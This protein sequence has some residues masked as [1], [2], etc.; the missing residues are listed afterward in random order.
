MAIRVTLV[1]AARALA[2]LAPAAAQEGH[3]G[4]NHGPVE[5]PTHGIEDLAPR[6]ATVGQRF[7]FVAMPKDGQLV[8]F[9]DHTETNAPAYGARIEILAGDALVTAEETAPGLYLVTPWPAEGL[10]V[11]DAGTVELIASVVAGTDEEVLLARMSGVESD[12]HAGHDHGATSSLP[13]GERVALWD[14]V[15]PFAVPVASGILAMF[16]AVT[17]LRSTGRRRWLGL[18]MSGVGIAS[19]IAASS[20][21]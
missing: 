20:L 5:A 18:S 12:D 14:N 7:Q 4:H 13:P 19:L 6:A 21:V 10:T 2:A 3:E 11:D 8:I 15:R 17:G 1:A 9:L 16:G